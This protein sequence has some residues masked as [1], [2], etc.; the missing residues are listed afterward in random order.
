MNV[1]IT[2]QWL[3]AVAR[4][5]SAVSRIGV[6]W[7]SFFVLSTCMFMCMGAHRSQRSSMDVIP[8][9]LFILLSET[10]SQ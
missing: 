1:L 10:G 5:K 8:Q 3:K 7:I 4:R 2:Q 6:N 9:E